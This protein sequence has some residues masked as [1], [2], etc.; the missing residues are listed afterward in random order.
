[1]R[2]IKRLDPDSTLD[3]ESLPVDDA[4]TYRL[5]QEGRT[6]A[7]FQPPSERASS[8]VAVMGASLAE[9]ERFRV[10]RRVRAHP[11]PGVTAQPAPPPG[12]G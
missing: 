9:H 5:F 3:L 7:I 1:M 8:T 6:D 11:R 10:T 2:Y 4:A 12:A